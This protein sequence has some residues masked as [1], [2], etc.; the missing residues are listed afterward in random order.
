MAGVVVVIIIIITLRRGRYF[1]RARTVHSQLPLNKVLLT[2]ETISAGFGK[3][4]GFQ[5]GRVRHR[6]V[7]A[8]DSFDWSVQIVER[9]FVHARGN[10]RT[11]ATS[12]ASGSLPRR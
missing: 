12:E 7:D 10:F 5:V 9:I 2:T 1:I 11:D 6:D 4:S 3:A 8:R